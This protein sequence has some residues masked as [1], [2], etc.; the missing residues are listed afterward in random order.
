MQQ[1]SS[2]LLPAVYGL[3]SA[4]PVLVFGVAIGRDVAGRLFERAKSADRWLL[5]SSGWS[6]AAIGVYLSLTRTFELF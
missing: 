4:A 1:K 3:G 6:M 5:P 2:L